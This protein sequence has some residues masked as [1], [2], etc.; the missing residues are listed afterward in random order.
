MPLTIFVSSKIRGM[1]DLRS[2]ARAVIEGLGHCPLMAEDFAAASS[3]P[4]GA[5]LDGVR[6]AD[7]IVLILGAEYGELQPSG[8]SATEEEFDEARRR[9]T[10][11]LVLRT[12]MEMDAAQRA[13]VERIGGWVDGALHRR[14][15]SRDDLTRELGR[16][17][18]AHQDA[19]GKAEILASVRERLEQV[20]L[21][22]RARGYVNH[23][24]RLSVAWMPSASPGLVDEARFFDELPDAIGDLLVAGPTRLLEARP[25]ASAETGR[26]VF[27]APH[28]SS[29]WTALEAVVW[30]DG[31][32]AVGV[33]LPDSDS[34]GIPGLFVLPPRRVEGQLGRVME[35]F[36]AITSRLDAD[37]VVRQGGFQVALENLGMAHL[38]DE[39]HG[40]PGRGITPRTITGG[41]ALLAPDEPTL[42]ARADLRVSS[43]K[44]KQFVKHLQR[45]S[46]GEQVFGA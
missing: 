45:A 39:I 1:E 32:M 2:A 4:R 31:S 5:C 41:G 21:G 35:L 7:V 34:S 23:V 20:M 43:A 16:A 12:T 17:L 25:Q 36:G 11:V 33:P 22:S 46:E 15:G 8:K 10:P 13:F 44:V 14:F 40:V 19:P 42:I 27:R 6:Q 30:V 28:R 26:L 3:T 9:S 24:P 29:S 38:R 18:R 37:G